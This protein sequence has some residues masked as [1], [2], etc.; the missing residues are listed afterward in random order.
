MPPGS[1]D[2]VAWVDVL[3]SLS[4][5]VPEL[6]KSLG[7]AMP[8]AGKQ[9]GEDFSKALQKQAVAGVEA[10]SDKLAAAR[11]KE[12]DA[13]GRLSVAE[14][15]LQ[16]LRDSGKAK[17][18]Q[19]AAAEEALA[20]A[21]RAV[22]DTMSGTERAARDLA[23]ASARAAEATD[24][25]GKA[26]GRMADFGDGAKRALT[27][28][29]TAVAAA[30][31]AVASGFFGNIAAG[32]GNDKLASQLGLDPK[33][34]EQ[35]GRV[36]G[37][38]Y[39]DAYGESLEQVNTAVGAVISSIDGMRTASAA[40]LEAVT[41]TALNFAAAFDTDV[42]EA[43]GL[44]G[45][46]IRNGL[47]K[48]S[49]EA[50]DLMTTAYQRVPAAMRAE[51][52]AILT[53][54]GTNFRALGFSGEEA[55]GLLVSAAQGGQFVLDKT[56][57]AL[58][59][60]SIR[61]TDMSATSVAAYDR[62]GL[63]AGEMANAILAGGDTAQEATAR[64]A[65][66]IL[67]IEDPAERA[68]TAI[69]LFGTPLE[70]LSVDQI[71]QF[72]TAISGTGGAMDGA[73]GAAGRMGD[74]L[75]DN[76]ATRLEGWKRNAMGFAQDG[77]LAIANGFTTGKT[78]SAGWQGAL[79]TVGAV[80]S[81]VFG[82]IRDEAVPAL[83]SLGG[84]VQSNTA[85]LVPLVGAIGAA[86]AVFQVVSLVTRAWAIAQGLLN[87]V[88]LA[89]PIVLVI[90]GLAALVAAV[91]LAY[92]KSETF[93]AIVDGAFRA[94]AAAGQWLW[95]SVL[96]PVFTAL[97]AAWSAVA[98]G[99][100]WAWDSIIK[101]IWDMVAFVA[102]ALLITLAVLVFG[103]ILVA[104]KVLAE[105]IQWAWNNVLKPAWDAV[106]AAAGWLWNSVL[107][108]VFGWIG[109]AWNA[110]GAGIGWVWRTL[111]KPMWDAAAAAAGWLWN[112]ALAPIFAAIGAGWNAMGAGL[113][114]VYDNVISPAW[115]ALKTGLQWVQDKFT[116]AVAW[117][118]SIWDTLRGKLAAPIN[119]LIETVWNNGIRKAW[120]VVA[121]LLPGIDPVAELA[122]I[123]E[124]RSGGAL[125]GPGT[126]TSDSILGID[127]RTHVPTA[128]VSNGEHVL[129]EREVKAAGGHDA[130][131]SW[132]R[133]LLAGGKQALAAFASG[134]QI[135]DVMRAKFPRAKLNSSYRPGDP[136]FHGRNMA[137]DLGE[138]GFAGGAGRAYIASMKEFAYD[139]YGRMSEIIYNGLGNSRPNKKNGQDY[140]YNR[141]TQLQHQNHLHLA[142]AG[143]MES[144]KGGGVWNGIV[145]AATGAL[146]WVTDMLG[147]VTS[148]FT[149]PARAIVNAIPFGSPPKFL[150]I[151][152]ALGNSVID[153]AESWFRSDAEQNGGMSTTSG[154]AA[155]VTG[156]GPVIDQV[157]AVA[158]SYGW[159]SGQ[160]WNALAGLI[161]GESGFN[162]N[163][164]N[165]TSSARGLFQKMTSLHGPIES[166]VAG[167][168]AW[169]LNYIKSAYGDPI[170][171]YAKWSSRKPHWYRDGGEVLPAFH[172]GGTVPGRRGEE[173]TARLLADER[174]LSPEQDNY[175]RR[176]IEVDERR[177]RQPMQW[178]GIDTGGGDIYVTSLDD[179]MREQRTQ[180]RQALAALSL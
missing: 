106:A 61:S 25:L 82:F 126:G 164:A 11:N 36:A 127:P 39:R 113:R 68:N 98:A 169:G 137:A 129:T 28:V 35:A 144:A 70:D 139:T 165:P 48:D 4:K 178:K 116:T 87:A 26:Q 136:G 32:Q 154:P 168:T 107:S 96:K 24:E 110:L 27:G 62:I 86:V 77:L 155:P 15:R 85:W 112:V 9:A 21:Q 3:P 151:P 50:F 7:A 163:A 173:V 177:D 43:V 149:T 179:L 80:G 47:A 132:R 109:A 72:L 22:A 128:W 147:K 44:A 156:S 97:T 161:R 23:T 13:A 174:V 55:F 146:D 152:K 65:Q 170:T 159:G 108:P 10:A 31:A 33:Q 114:W 150:G 138:A 122:K 91:V 160:Q 71:P 102:K 45:N 8:A 41:G 135:F 172:G 153:K 157:R 42:T 12:A 101:P 104:W 176:F 66:G 94:V 92:Q 171:A 79:E 134:G 19:L 34:A 123:P 38:L 63:N 83:S 67:S 2:D 73:A 125:H 175:W 37:A 131:Y 53:E 6:R 166:T 57:D 145:D 78:T 60:F 118:G 46:L 180:Q 133:S 121:D 99:I 59:E 30:G 18:S 89:N 16:E 141:A 49:T 93:R 17:A 14:K 76:F 105:G 29:V 120:N 124:R 69:A 140:P 20:K 130:I 117:I 148:L 54:Y 58:K 1:S 56:G 88:L 90:A 81:R 100:A 51:L 74:T 143:S 162:P 52:P 167:Q 75:N 5:F 142:Q 40:D 103:P 115:E 111:I 84:W 64:I 95:D 119:F 158:N